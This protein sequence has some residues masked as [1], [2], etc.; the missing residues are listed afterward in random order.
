MIERKHLTIGL[1][2]YRGNSS[3]V[4]GYF[5][6]GVPNPRHLDE[7]GVSVDA[8]EVFDEVADSFKQSG[9]LQVTFSGTRRAYAELGRYFLAMSEFQALNP[10]YHDHL[11]RL[12]K[13]E[14]K[15]EVELIVRLPGPQRVE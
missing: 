2:F 12:A 7:L 5:E 9:R 4:E 10:Q 3:P 11:D 14:G 13:V 8:E 1:E 6:E 15:R